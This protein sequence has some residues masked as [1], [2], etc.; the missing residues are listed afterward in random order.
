LVG[1]EDDKQ[2]FSLTT[3][4]HSGAEVKIPHADRTTLLLFIRVNQ[5]QS[6]R[7]VAE[8][9]KA[10]A[11]MPPAQVLAIVSGRQ[12]DDDIKKLA[13]QIPWPVITDKD[14]KIVGKLKVRVW[15]TVIA[16][17]PSGQ[18]LARLTGSPQ[19]YV[20]DMNAYLA[21]AAKKIDRDTLNK[22]LSSA[23]SVADSPYE[24]AR[25]HLRVA[26][27]LIERDQLALAQEELER[28]L[29][30]QPKNALLLL[31]KARLLLMHRKP[32]KA[33]DVLSGLDKKTALAAKIGTLEGWAMVQLKQWDQ[34]IRILQVSVKL[35]PE[36]SAAYY[37]MGLAY[38]H[39]DMNS[40]AARAFR[41][42]FESTQTGRL[43]S[44]SPR[45]ATTPTTQPTTRPGKQPT[46]RPS[47]DK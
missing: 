37:F 22:R 7:T 14:Y 38:A 24:M 29:K 3:R 30:I 13:S 46:T 21:F 42:A 32:S 40:D 23:S 41:S 43:V 18:E 9:K 4:D 16:I 12:D 26:E 20:S 31:V 27:R 2:I 28:G 35:N 44:A 10:L 45:P 19:A 5:E 8:T 25:R 1:A 11:D 17:L 6:L 39:K 15:P 33:M 34:A 36:P 47:D